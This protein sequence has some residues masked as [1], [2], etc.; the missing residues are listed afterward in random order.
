MIVFYFIVLCYISGILVFP[1]GWDATDVQSICGTKAGIY[2]MGNCS[3]G[4]SYI[5]IIIGT[6]IAMTAMAMSW[7]TLLKRKS[8]GDASYAL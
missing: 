4:W 1:V 2:D 7:T 6:G 5:V 8:D 3:I